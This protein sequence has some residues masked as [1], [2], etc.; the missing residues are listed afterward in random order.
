MSVSKTGKPPSFSPSQLFPFRSIVSTVLENYAAKRENMRDHK[1]R[2]SVK[3]LLKL[4]FTIHKLYRL[5]GG[6]LNLQYRLC[7]THHGGINNITNHMLYCIFRDFFQGR[8]ILKEK[9]IFLQQMI[10]ESISQ[11]YN[12]GV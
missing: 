4:L 6:L 8:Y 11:N 1:N 2:S 12:K 9:R 10:W 5:P 3:Q 7:T